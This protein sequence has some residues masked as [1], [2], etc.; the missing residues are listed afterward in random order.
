MGR[1]IPAAVPASIPAEV[2]GVIPGGAGWP[3]DGLVEWYDFS[4]GGSAVQVWNSL[5]GFGFVCWNGATIG[6][7]ATDGTVGK[8]GV[9]L[10]GS[11]DYLSPDSVQALVGGSSYITDVY[12][13]KPAVLQASTARDMLSDRIIN[14]PATSLLSHWFTDTGKITCGCRS[15]STDAFQ[16]FTS[17]SAV[18]ST[19]KWVLLAI[20]ID[21]IAATIRLYVNGVFREAKTG[22]VFANSILIPETP[23]G[24]PDKFG[25][26][27]SLTPARYFN[28]IFKDSLLYKKKLSDGDHKAMYEYSRDMLSTLGESAW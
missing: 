17:A 10:D 13:V 18:A 12:L 24:R 16:S 28:G 1:G 2:P 6:A 15:K 25:I 20:E 27:A 8:L 26:N 3:T 23:T 22:C 21:Y 7:E 9:T 4:L 11:A 19:G 14:G 5:A